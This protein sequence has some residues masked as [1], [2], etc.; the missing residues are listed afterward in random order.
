MDKTHFTVVAGF[1]AEADHA[2][3]LAEAV[4]RA[5]FHLPNWQLREDKWVAAEIVETVY[6]YGMRYASGLHNFG[7]IADARYLGT[8]DKALQYAQEWVEAQD[9]YASGPTFYVFVRNTALA[10]AG[11]VAEKVAARVAAEEQ[12]ARRQKEAQEAISRISDMHE[13]CPECQSGGSTDPVVR[14]VVHAKYHGVE[15]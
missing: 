12:A 3:A 11:A 2:K 4:T 10:N 8:L 6:G 13:D 9:S 15:P 14:G 7:I 1:K 5:G